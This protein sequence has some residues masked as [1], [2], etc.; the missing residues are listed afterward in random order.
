MTLTEVYETIRNE[1]QSLNNKYGDR[2]VAIEA[3]DGVLTV[4]MYNKSENNYGEIVD[5]VLKNKGEQQ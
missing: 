2:I 5:E 3:Y 1:L 4:Y